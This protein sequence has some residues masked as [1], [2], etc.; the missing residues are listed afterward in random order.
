M[1]LERCGGRQQPTVPTQGALAAEGASGSL[2]PSKTYKSKGDLPK[3]F[4]PGS[5]ENQGG[6]GW[7]ETQSKTALIIPKPTAERCRRGLRAR[8]A[9]AQ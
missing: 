7:D 1:P 5:E 4:P 2:N 6:N 3:R 9:A 8:R